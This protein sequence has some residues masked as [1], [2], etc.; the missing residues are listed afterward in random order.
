MN[1]LI[2]GGMGYIGAHVAKILKEEG[3]NI[4]L[5]DNLSNYNRHQARYGTLIIGN[6]NNYELLVKTMKEKSI[7]A[8]IHLAGKSIVSE[9]ARCKLKYY[10]NNVA[11][12]LSLMNA[13]M[14]L[15]IFNFVFA[16]SAAVYGNSK[17]PL[18]ETDKLD[19]TNSYGQSKLLCEYLIKETCPHYVILRYFNV[20]GCV[21][22]I[23]EIHYPETHLIPNLMHAI[24]TDGIFNIYGDG[25][26]IR[27]YIYVDDVAR[28]TAAAI[29]LKSNMVCNV[30]TGI[31]YSVNEIVDI[32]RD[33]YGNFSV[34]KED[35]RIGD[36][37]KLIA[38]NSLLKKWYKY[39]LT[40]I[41]NII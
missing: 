16:S 41:N 8:V 36:P 5:Y 15:N 30:G 18:K 1:I 33:K 35:R 9:S 29:K 4:I 25:S 6:I 14:K 28:I 12:T 20:C 13:C 11:G 23:E 24:E 27:D 2:T 32:M 40:P 31:G 22:P 19:P 21:S 26:C 3:H 37:S 38:D 10:Y 34:I 17:E 39:D 7:N